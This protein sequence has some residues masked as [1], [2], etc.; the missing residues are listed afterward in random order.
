MDSDNV[1]SGSGMSPQPV[2][3]FGENERLTFTVNPD[4]STKI[5]AGIS[6]NSEETKFTE[7]LNRGG[8]LMHNLYDIYDVLGPR[9]GELFHQMTDQ[10]TV[11]EN[12]GIPFVGLVSASLQGGYLNHNTHGKREEIHLAANQIFVG[13]PGGK[14][15]PVYRVV[16]DNNMRRGP[17]HLLYSARCF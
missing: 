12:A 5:S 8:D 13:P 9:V 6:V 17:E 3:P 15:S 7:S 4:N 16:I 2:F 14:K 1:P 11:H 10:V